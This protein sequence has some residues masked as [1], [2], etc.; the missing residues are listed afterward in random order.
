M[1]IVSADYI[2]PAK[3]LGKNAHPSM[4]GLEAASQTFKRGDILINSGGYLKKASADP[5][6][7]IVG[8]A[9]EDGNNTSAG[10]AIS[11]Y[12]AMQ[13][14]IF[15]G[16]VYHSSAASAVNKVT[17]TF[18]DYGL[19]RSSTAN[20]WMVD[21]TESSTVKKTVKIV[22]HKDALS[23]TNGTVYFIFNKVL[24]AHSLA[25]STSAV[26]TKAS[27]IIW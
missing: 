27:P 1:A 25:V 9:A 21:K 12:P 16:V 4:V 14:V 19:A 24:A 3:M 17:D 23:T 11:F 22:G 13:G 2:K 10:T 5:V 8:I 18:V 7:N 6:A 26:T 20:V 15:E